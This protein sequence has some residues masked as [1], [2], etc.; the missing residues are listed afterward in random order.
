M[1]TSCRLEPPRAGELS[2]E[3]KEVML[4]LQVRERLPAQLVGLACFLINPL[5]A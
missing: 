3:S 5:V 1:R 2:V 4:S